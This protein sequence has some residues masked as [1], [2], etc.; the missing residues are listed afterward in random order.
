MPLI[1]YF[2]LMGFG[3]I[4]IPQY[5]SSLRITDDNDNRITDDG[6]NRTTDGI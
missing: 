2:I 1:F 4:E 3:K 5:L 6:N